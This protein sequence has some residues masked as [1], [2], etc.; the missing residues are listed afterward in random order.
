MPRRAIADD[1]NVYWAELA[2][3]LLKN[4]LPVATRSLIDFLSQSAQPLSEYCQFAVPR[5]FD[6]KI[7]LTKLTT[8]K[9]IDLNNP[10]LLESYT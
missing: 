6:W 7:A 8:L 10:V 5:G 4:H 1:R 2:T 3:Q 9:S